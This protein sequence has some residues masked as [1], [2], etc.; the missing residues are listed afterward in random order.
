MAGV[1]PH[2]LF[3]SLSLGKV[4]NQKDWGKVALLNCGAEAFWLH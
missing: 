1:V 3:L 2:H 4:L